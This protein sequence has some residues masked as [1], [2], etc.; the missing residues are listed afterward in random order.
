MAVIPHYLKV[1]QTNSKK[2]DSENLTNN[3]LRQGIIVKAFTPLD[4]DNT[5]GKYTEYDVKV[6]VRNGTKG[7]SNYSI[8]RSVVA[9]PFGGSD[10][11]KYSLQ[12][13]SQQPGIEQYS[14]G[15]QVLILC[16]NGVTANAV[17]ISGLNNGTP[18]Q[19]GD[20]V[21]PT[22]P[23]D[24]IY[25]NFSFNGVKFDIGM[26]GGIKLQINGATDI[27]GSPN[28]NNPDTNSGS[29]I[30]IDADGSIN[31]SNN[32]KTNIS[33]DSNGHVN[34][35]SDG[36][37]TIDADGDTNIGSADADQQLVQGNN[38][39]D[40]LSAFIDIFVQNAPGFTL[41]GPASPAGALQPPVLQA[42]LQW[43]LQYLTT[44]SFLASD[45]YTE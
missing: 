6:I 10:Y 30:E 3:S 32:D 31:I 41:P 11:L 21:T 28:K 15:A 1:T 23:S 8:Y 19:D 18:K 36:N 2:T 39:V 43:K 27:D 29:L 24:P 22:D 17:I 44:K 4:P 5:N 9:N 34:I 13:D 42:I 12:P 25:F 45:K 33:I 26:D 16:I 7:R 35:K 37:I 40:A 38:L 20:P 14:L